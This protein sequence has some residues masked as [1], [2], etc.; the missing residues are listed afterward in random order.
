MPWELTIVTAAKEE[1]TLKSPL[2]KSHL[3]YPSQ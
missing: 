2:E 3:T 1:K